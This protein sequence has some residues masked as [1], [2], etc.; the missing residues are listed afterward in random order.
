M[1]YPLPTSMKKPKL[2]RF[3]YEG[4]NTVHRVRA[5]VRVKVK[6]RVRVG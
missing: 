3:A 2:S 5:R 6:V 1:L 4:S